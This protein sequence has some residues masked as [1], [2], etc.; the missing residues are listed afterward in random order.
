MDNLLYEEDELTM[1]KQNVAVDWDYTDRAASYDKRADYN[2]DALQDLFNKLGLR[3]GDKVADLGAG[4][5]KLTAPLL[6]A[7]F[8]VLAVEPNAV[9]RELGVANTVGRDVDWLVGSGEKTGLKKSSV[10]AALFG[11]SFNVVDQTRA[12]IEVARIVEPSGGFACMWNHRD[13]DDPVQKQIEEVIGSFVSNFGYGKRREDPTQ[14]LEASGFFGPVS[15]IERRFYVDVDRNNFMEA[16]NSHA[17][18]ARQAGDRFD[19]VITAIEKVVPREKVIRVPYV[20][21]IW[22]AKLKT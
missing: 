6:D 12:L 1:L 18:V 7:G 15:A 17:T 5:G 20:T 16:W 14:V 21:R 22:W 10:K 3:V 2:P 11:S 13:L 4:T 19:E 9:M 8:E